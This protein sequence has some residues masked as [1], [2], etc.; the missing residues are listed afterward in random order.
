[1]PS[2]ESLLFN[3]LL[4]ALMYNKYPGILSWLNETEGIF[5]LRC[6]CKYQKK[7][8]SKDTNRIFEDYHKLKPRK[9]EN[10]RQTLLL[11]LKASPSTKILEDMSTKEVKYYKLLNKTKN[12]P[13]VMDSEML[14]SEDEIDEIFAK[15]P[16]ST[17]VDLQY[18]GL[19]NEAVETPCSSSI[20]CTNLESVNSAPYENDVLG[21]EDTLKD[22]SEIL[23]YNENSI[24][25]IGDEASAVPCGDEASGVPCGNEAS[26]VPCGNEASG[27]PF[28]N[29]ASGVPFG[30]EAS[31][32][33]FGNEA[34]GVPF[35]NEASG[36][37]F[38]NE[39]SGVSFRGEACTVPDDAS[40]LH[41]MEHQAYP[42]DYDP[43]LDLFQSIENK[44]TFSQEIPVCYSESPQWEF[45]GVYCVNNGDEKPSHLLRKMKEL[46]NGQLQ[47]DFLQ[48]LWFQRMPPH[49]QTV[50]SASL[51]ALG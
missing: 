31:G 50:L 44:K 33:P 1:M 38:G 43:V 34:S 30:N 24:L 39:A 17:S 26:G 51:G 49:I 5:C 18:S 48:S 20:E 35:G 12:L 23:G 14:P 46:S 10:K 4:N 36:V 11:A 42:D 6:V 28:G 15:S 40:D 47:D 7:K 3:F 45:K 9:S 41:L 8:W 2:K 13:L 16:I 27:V 32:V 37:P 22:L 19:K 29:E 25:N 21:M